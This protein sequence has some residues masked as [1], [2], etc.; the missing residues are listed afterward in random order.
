MRDGY[1]TTYNIDLKSDGIIVSLR[2][3]VS[4]DITTRNPTVI[5]GNVNVIIDDDVGDSLSAGEQT[6]IGGDVDVTITN[7]IHNDRVN[8]NLDTTLVIPNQNVLNNQLLNQEISLNNN[9]NNIED[10]STISLSGKTNILSN[11]I[12]SKRS[13]L[14]S[15]YTPSKTYKT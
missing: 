13:K 12:R 4:E 8:Q 6:V 1:I 2:Q 7:F 9:N 11:L 3:R 5:L 15:S 10:N 14:I